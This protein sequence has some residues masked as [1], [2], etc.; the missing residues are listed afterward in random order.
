L[1][2]L[3]ILAAV[4]GLALFVPATAHARLAFTIEGNATGTDATAEGTIEIGLLTGILTLTLENTSPFD[5]RITGVGVNIGLGNLGPFTGNDPDGAGGF[6]FRDG[7]LGNVPQ[8]QG[9]ILDFGW[10]TSNNGKFTS[11]KPNE[12]LAPGD[13]LVFTAHDL[14]GIDEAEVL[15]GLF[16][17][18]QRVGGD[19]EGSDVGKGEGEPRGGPDPG[20]IPEAG[21]MLLFGSGLAAF[22]A[23]RRRRRN[24]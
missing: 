16:V 8:F 21:S 19:G 9:N 3:T 5:A 12:G 20:D 6:T 14:S 1:R 17:R 7:N 18:F 2:K 13:Q 23:M 11:G 15:A 4:V 24:G 10:T 22:A